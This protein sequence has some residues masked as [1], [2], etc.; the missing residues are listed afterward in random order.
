[1]PGSTVALDIFAD[2]DE[3][4]DAVEKA[5]RKI[6]REV[7]IPGFRKGKAPRHI[8]D[9]MIGRDAVAQEAGQEMMDDLYRRAIAQEQIIPVGEPQVELLQ[10]DPIGFKVV[11]EVFPTVTLGDY[12]GVRVE[13][14]EVE[15]EDSE[16]DEVVEQLRRQHSEWVE[17]E[18]PRMAVEGD[19][20]MLDLDVYEGEEQFQAPTR[21]ATFIIGETPLFDSIVEAI[22]MM[23][24]GTTADMTLAFDEDD[25]SVDEKLRGKVLR[26]ELTLKGIRQRVL[27]EADDALA[28]KVSEE[29]ES[30]DAM[31][32][33]IRTDL[34]RNKAMETRGEIATQVINAM[35]ETAEMELPASMIEKELDDELTQFRSR[36]AQQRL[37]LDEYLDHNNQTLDQLREEMRPNA[38][39][40]VRNSLVLQEIAKAEEIA[41][42]EEDVESEIERL[43]APADDPQRLRTL[44]RSDY[45]RGLLE[46]E[47]FERKLTNRLLEIATEGRGPVTGSG[48]EA[49]REALEPP[50]R[51]ARDAIA[52]EV[53]VAEELE[54][55]QPPLTAE[56]VN[57]T[58]NAEAA[59]AIAAS[60]AEVVGSAALTAD[61]IEVEESEP[62]QAETA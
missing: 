6:A 1:M 60:D 50:V 10:A 29:Y 30:F 39:R 2:Q 46:N 26:Y 32:R 15:I 40:R 11:I 45:F 23:M 62:A 36:L 9:R 12:Q 19:Q 55:A 35:S 37:T 33:Q 13:P 17:P 47:I 54:D 49:L 52:D 3:F 61:A 53:E 4:A 21:D 18:T 57:E 56:V 41:A 27:P 8:L 48:A 5:Y 38:Q 25:D 20:I 24:P 28:T 44:Y 16:V 34:L 22:K 31:T 51:P 59:D 43:S 42:T 58:A 7:T 14:R